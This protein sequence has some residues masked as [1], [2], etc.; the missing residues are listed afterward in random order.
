MKISDED[1]CEEICCGWGELPLKKLKEKSSHEIPLLGGT[2]HAEIKIDNKDVRDNRS[3][4]NAMAKAFGG[5][6]K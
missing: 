1:D 6:K 3:G 4:L 5:I 2:P